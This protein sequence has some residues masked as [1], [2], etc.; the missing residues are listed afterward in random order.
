MERREP[1]QGR[2]RQGRIEA[3]AQRDRL[4]RDS[5][6]YVARLDLD[7]ATGRGWDHHLPLPSDMRLLMERHQQ[8]C[9]VAEAM[10]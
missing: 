2:Y 10:P 6:W 4:F 9:R 8:A 7:A 1:E 3:D 5:G